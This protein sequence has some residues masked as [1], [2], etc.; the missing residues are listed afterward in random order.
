[1]G[2]AKIEERAVANLDSSGGTEVGRMFQPEAAGRATMLEGGADGIIIETQTD[3][4][5][6]AEKVIT[7][8][9]RKNRRRSETYL[10]ALA[11]PRGEKG[12][13]NGRGRR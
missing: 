9:E 4:E 6:A 1:M 5:E 13:L 10:H 11:D 8:P 3:L 7:G 12:D 2:M